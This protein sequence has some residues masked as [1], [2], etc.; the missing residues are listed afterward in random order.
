MNNDTKYNDLQ[1]FSTIYG[2]LSSMGCAASQET[3]PLSTASR[4]I[5]KK[6]QQ[7]RK[8]LEKETAVKLLLLGT[9][10]SGKSTLL[11]QMKIIHGL[12]F[13]NDEMIMYR[14]AIWLNLL[15][16][17][18]NLTIAMDNLK[19]PYGF[20][21]PDPKDLEAMELPEEPDINPPSSQQDD[22][23]GPRDSSLDRPPIIKH[24]KLARYAALQ[25][26]NLGGKAQVGEVPDAARMMKT[27]DLLVS[28]M[29]SF[30]NGE[31][32]PA[33]RV[34][35]LDAIWNDSGIQY[36][37]QRA[38]EFQ[39]IESCAFLMQHR[40][41]ICGL[42]YKPTEED[43]LS[44][45][46]MTTSVSETR[47]R[48]KDVIYRVF[49]VGGQKSQRKK[50]APLFEDVDAIIFVVAISSYNQVCFEAKDTNRSKFLILYV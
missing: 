43:I 10:E 6:L 13:T 29:F 17:Y 46:I 5:D 18:Q 38:A 39:L 32:F 40:H 45:R 35:G 37:F 1:I 50:W 30:S 15:T 2:N 4:I 23:N 36:C 21:P 7:E 34:A 44:A 27:S 8:E 22:S 48:I 33:D 28:S 3:D 11:K 9:G 25:Y 20:V 41:R 14:S 19:I 42:G 49:D 31:P 26:E 16:C 12:G 47:F 24:D